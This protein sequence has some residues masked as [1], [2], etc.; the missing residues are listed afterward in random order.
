MSF[1]GDLNSFSLADVFQNLSNN[2]QT[3][4][5]RVF[6]K[7]TEKHLF[8]SEGSVRTI[9][10]GKSRCARIGQILLARKKIT[11]QHLEGALASQKKDKKLLIGEILLQQQ[12]CDAVAIEEALKFQITEEVYDL[13]NWNQARFEFSEGSM[14][15]SIFGKRSRVSEIKL[16]TASLIMEAVRRLDE[17]GRINSLIPSLVM[18]P[19]RINKIPPG[20]EFTENTKSIFEYCDGKHT[21]DSISIDSCLGVYSV[22]QGLVVLIQDGLVRDS[23]I[24]ELKANA[25]SL[26]LA[27]NP[28]KATFL[29]KWIFEITEFD[30][31]TAELLIAALEGAGSLIEAAEYC[32]ILG[33]F[34]MD[35]G[36]FVDAITAFEKAGKLA[37]L[38]GTDMDRLAELYIVCKREQDAENIWLGRARSLLD[39]KE[40]SAALSVCSKALEFIPNSENIVSLN[41]RIYLDAGNSQLAAE[42]YERLANIY[43]ADRNTKGAISACRSVLKLDASRTDI[44]NRI[45][46]LQAR[47]TL[48][49]TKKRNR[50][51]VVA[52]SFLFLS[53]VAGVVFFE[54]SAQNSY[55]ELKKKTNKVM[56]EVKNEDVPFIKI[57]EELELQIKKCKNFKPYFSLTNFKIM[58]DDKVA[59]LEKAL[60]QLKDNERV[61]LAENEK[62]DRVAFNRAIALIKI[63]KAKEIAKAD[64]ILQKIVSASHNNEWKIKAEKEIAK[65]QLSQQ[66][67]KELFASLKDKNYAERFFIVKKLYE[68]FPFSKYARKATIPVKVTVSP[69][70]PTLVLLNDKKIGMIKDAGLV[71]EL[72]IFGGFEISLIRKGFGSRNGET[73]WQGDENFIDSINN[74]NLKIKLK[75]VCKWKKEVGQPI[76][77]N[78]VF[79]DLFLADNKIESIF[80]ATAHGAVIAYSVI[81]GR[82]LWRYYDSKEN[83]DFRCSPY[84]NKDR[85]YIL[86]YS[87]RLV[88]LERATGRIIWPMKGEDNAESLHSSISNSPKFVNLSFYE[89]KLFCLAGTNNGKLI[90]LSTERGK[91]RWKAYSTGSKLPITGNIVYIDG[92]I[93]FV[94][95]LG[96]IHLIESDG[97]AINIIE[98]KDIFLPNIL[99][100][101]KQIIT[102]T[103]S[104]VVSSWQ[105]KPKLKQLWTSDKALG[106]VRFMTLNNHRI[107]CTLDNTKIVVLSKQSGKLITETNDLKYKVYLGPVIQDNLLINVGK[108]SLFSLQMDNNLREGWKYVS[109]AKSNITG[110]STSKKYI[111]FVNDKGTLFLLDKDSAPQ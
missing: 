71:L 8:F 66:E 21:I 51:V 94:D 36:M 58:I 105:I 18:V 74:P 101:N 108:N 50:A 87:G 69:L 89:D 39:S 54:V 9:S 61:R 104:G 72:P 7:D 48:N 37:T 31:E 40:I 2:Q 75:R 110:I 43:D 4:V 95:G 73:L 26:V 70:L 107:I 55:S 19:N 41:A 32:R 91:M 1:A 65:I 103:K 12:S 49:K 34:N 38:T 5:L 3:G 86:D 23:E 60:K 33:K 59:L 64:A 27:G 106:D 96:K 79:E 30:K 76:F 68:K 53:I 25:E 88:C 20:Y 90:C 99:K 52:I 62:N 45:E 24:S 63:G 93:V 109:T 42:C 15:T 67:A 11:R 57:K 97:S 82:E 111:S 81:T 46:L 6:D 85:I 100:I 56:N 13:F 14:G 80:V 16:N 35:N 83:F 84:F 78:P 102:V 44:R 77:S 28:E 29:Y 98:Q 17:W 10:T 22:T 47:T 92:I